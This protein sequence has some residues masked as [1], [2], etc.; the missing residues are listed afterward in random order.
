VPLPFVILGNYPHSAFITK[1]L[2][3]QIF[4]VF[5]TLIVVRSYMM[6]PAHSAGIPAIKIDISF[7]A[8]S[9]PPIP[10]SRKYSGFGTGLSRHTPVKGD[11]YAQKHHAQHI[12][13]VHGDAH[14]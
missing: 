13:Y 11:E 8:D 10:N 12:R 3:V 7:R 1:L 9:S 5:S 4:M 2:S 14:A 6:L